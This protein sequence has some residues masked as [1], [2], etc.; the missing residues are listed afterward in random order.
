MIERQRVTLNKP[1][2]RGNITGY[3]KQVRNDI[4]IVLD[5]KKSSGGSDLFNGINL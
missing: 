1:Q 2:N 4:S 3:Y 5:E